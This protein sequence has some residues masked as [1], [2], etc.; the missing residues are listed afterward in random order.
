MENQNTNSWQCPNCQSLNLNTAKFCTKCG[1]PNSLQSI[2]TLNQNTNAWQCPN[3]KSS[4]PDTA[5]FCKSCGT[6]NPSQ[7]AVQAQPVQNTIY[8]QQS[9]QALQAKPTSGLAVASM[10][11]GI[12][13]LVV[14][15]FGV[16]GIICG[17][18]AVI[19]GGCALLTKKGG[20][21]MAVA[22]LV[23]GIIALI[24]SIIVISTVGSIVDALS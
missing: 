13:S 2:N 15:C 8:L 20:K 10:V 21:G 23:C 19:L 11:L 3:C 4:N 14:S 16:V 12:L 6:P 24:P 9:A 5:K 7:S 22:G 18:L 1:A 17:I